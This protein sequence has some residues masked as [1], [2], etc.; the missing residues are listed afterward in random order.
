MK[1]QLRSLL[2]MPEDNLEQTAFLTEIKEE[3]S[4]DG[5]QE[6]T[7]QGTFMMPQS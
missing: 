7:T 3:A 2:E 1:L 4:D 5:Y 6:S